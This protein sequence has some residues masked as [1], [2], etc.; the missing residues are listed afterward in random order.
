M[1]DN[2]VSYLIHSRDILYCLPVV[3]SWLAATYDKQQPLSNQTASLQTASDY[4]CYYGWG[5]SAAPWGANREPMELWSYLHP[6]AV[7]D[8]VVV[9]EV[10]RV[11][12]P[13]IGIYLPGTEYSPAPSSCRALQQAWNEALGQYWVLNWHH[14]N[15]AKDPGKHSYAMLKYLTLVTAHM[16]CL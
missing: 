15:A 4:W 7:V 14:S 9:S 3:A 16:C 2:D 11:S 5:Y 1:P 6:L 12:L 8:T 10:S 13:G